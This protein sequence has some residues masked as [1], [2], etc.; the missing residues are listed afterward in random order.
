[1]GVGPEFTLFQVLILNMGSDIEG[2]MY[3][4]LLF[5]FVYIHTMDRHWALL[6]YGRHLP[7]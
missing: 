5:E 7:P 4:L 3:V 6:V 2:I 1:M